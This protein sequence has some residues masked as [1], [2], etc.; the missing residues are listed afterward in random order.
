MISCSRNSISCDEKGSSNALGRTK[1]FY[2]VPLWTWA[3][4]V[5]PLRCINFSCVHW[6]TFH[7]R[8][9]DRYQAPF[10]IPRFDR[11]DI[12]DWLDAHRTL[13]LIGSREV[14]LSNEQCLR[15]WLRYHLAEPKY[16]DQI[17]DWCIQMPWEQSRYL[18]CF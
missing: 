9:L 6:T 5:A 3:F 14:D 4:S 2:I 10:D 16:V 8:R 1:L 13:D 11:S 17:E 12:S 7:I 15:S 18:Q